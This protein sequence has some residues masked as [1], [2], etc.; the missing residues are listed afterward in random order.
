MVR[1]NRQYQAGSD[2]S[3]LEKE[4]TRKPQLYKVLLHNDDY[5]TMEF[6]VTVLRKIFH[7]SEAEALHTM[8]TVHHKGVGVAGIYTRETS[9]TKVNQVHEFAREHQHPLKCSMEPE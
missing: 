9:E 8:L 1:R 6:V 3:I 4:K 5:T 7:K 2:T